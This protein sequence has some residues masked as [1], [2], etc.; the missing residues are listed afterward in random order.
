MLELVYFE[1]N[2]WFSDRDYPNFEPFKTWVESYILDNDDWCREN[3]LAVLSGFIDMSK[4]WCITATKSW[5]QAHCPELLEDLPYTYVTELH[6][7]NGI[8]FQKHKKNISDFLRYPD[9]DGNVYGKFGWEFPEYTE[10]NFGVHYYDE[11]EDYVRYS[12]ET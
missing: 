12:E 6:S 8:Q 10:E 4:N 7:K 9:E 3:R 1:L 11:G 2:N 5:I